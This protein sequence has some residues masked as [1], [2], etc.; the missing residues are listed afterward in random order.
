MS[1]L[2]SLCMCLVHLSPE[3]FK[4][5]WKMPNRQDL[6]HGCLLDWYQSS[7]YHPAELISCRRH[8]SSTTW[9]GT[10]K[11]HLGATLLKG[12][13]LCLV[14]AV[15]N[16]G[17]PNPVSSGCPAKFAWKSVELRDEW[18]LNVDAPLCQK[19][20]RAKIRCFLLLK[21]ALNF[22]PTFP[23]FFCED[24]SCFV[25]WGTETTEN[26]ANNPAI[27]ECQIPRQIRRKNHESFL[28]SRQGNTP[29]KLSFFL[30]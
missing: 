12:G 28:E 9:A 25:S 14:Y 24:F 7:C 1:L 10:R 18:H 11:S 27:F 4:Q 19:S 2:L 16:S 6:F 8:T 5:N 15:S 20:C 22:A 21:F 26:W 13:C 17:S 29:P 3:K 30:M 23:R